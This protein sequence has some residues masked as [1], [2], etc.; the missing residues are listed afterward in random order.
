MAK[1]TL[2]LT[3]T[4]AAFQSNFNI[5]SRNVGDPSLLLTTEDSDIVGAINELH[6]AVNLL[7]S[8][9]GLSI[10]QTLA[11]VDSDI[12]DV[13]LSISS[14]RDSIDNTL[15]GHL[16]DLNTTDKTTVVDAINELDRRLVDVYN[17]SGTLLNT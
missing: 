6:T 2:S 9:L 11:E 15:V 10:E 5:V 3:D 4:I 8:N 1:P 13:I 16:A 14:L 17:S 7:D 12:N